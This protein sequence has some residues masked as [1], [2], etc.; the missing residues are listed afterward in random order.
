M[1]QVIEHYF[2]YLR[3]QRNLSENTLKA[4][5]RDLKAFSD[6]V[7]EYWQ[8][9]LTEVDRHLIRDYLA[10]LH[11]KGYKQ[12]HCAAVSSTAQFLSVSSEIWPH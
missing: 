8:I 7:S 1:N 5:K 3:V 11:R 9:D 2:Q 4:Y 6:F 10:V 12:Q